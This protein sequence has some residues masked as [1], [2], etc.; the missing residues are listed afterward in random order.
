MRR[1]S[2]QQSR[3]LDAWRGCAAIAVLIAHIG[4]IFIPNASPAWGAL[5]TGAVMV[6]FV[7]SGFFIR[8]SLEKRGDFIAARVNRIA[9]PFAFA[10]VLTVALWFIAPLVFITGDRSF[11]VPTTQQAYTLKNVLP[12]VFLVSWCV[13]GTIPA[14]EPLW[15]LAYEVF[16]YALVAFR[17]VRIALLGLIAASVVN[18]AVGLLGG[19]W[20]AGFWIAKLHSE[21]RLP[22]CPQWPFL[23]LATAAAALLFDSSG[24]TLLWW[25]LSVGLAFAAHLLWLLKRVPPDPV[26]IAKSAEWSYTLYLIH[27][28]LLLFAYGMGFSPLPSAAAVLLLAA[29]IGPRIERVKILKLPLVLAPLR[30][31]PAIS[32]RA[33]PSD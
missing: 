25:E 17:N 19:V 16:Y 5:G 8:K 33:S 1:I 22:S 15:S 27:Y 11:V 20:F 18:P 14:N 24:S 4:Q 3:Y 12:T 30:G 6:F 9:A 28:P 13:G 21:D 23:V 7:I 32:S 10:L 31:A 26:H 29:L 2:P